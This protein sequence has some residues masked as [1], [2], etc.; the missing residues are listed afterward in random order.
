MPRIALT[1]TADGPTRADI[2]AGLR[3]GR[4]PVR[5]QLRPAQHP[6]SH[7]GKKEPLAQLLRFIA[8]A[9]GR[10]RRRLLP[11][12]QGVE[13]MAQA[14]QDGGINALPYHAGLPADLRHHQDRFLREDG[15][16]MVATIAFGMGIDKPDVRFVAHV[17]MPEKHRG[18]YRR[19]RAGRDGLPAD[20]WMVYGLQD[21]V[22]QRRMIDDGDAAR[23]SRPCCA[24]SS[25]PCS[26]PGR[27]HG[28]LAPAP[29]GLLW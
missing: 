22:N 19:P 26:A 13:E 6:L 18:Y 1:A 8:R 17:D 3:L 28:L 21:V 23:S 7:R 10:R 25:T 27:G 12:A 4:A 15:I 5:Q 24:A 2:V 20:A 11:V 9:P 14:L 16:V 29:A